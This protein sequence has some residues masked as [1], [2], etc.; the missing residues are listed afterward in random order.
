MLTYRPYNSMLISLVFVGYTILS[1]QT[2]E[3]C[4]PPMKTQIAYSTR[5]RSAG[6][7]AALKLLLIVVVTAV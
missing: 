3:N 1:R 2:V 5:Q 7:R 4:H 6:C